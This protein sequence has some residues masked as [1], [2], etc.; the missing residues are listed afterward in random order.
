MPKKT[1]K[2]NSQEPQQPKNTK[3]KKILITIVVCI[4]VVAVASKLVNK[5]LKKIKAEQEKAKIE[6]QAEKNQK[7]K[8]LDNKQSSEET[9]HQT[10]DLISKDTPSNDKMVFTFYNNLKNHRV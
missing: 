2:V 7:S 5:H 1:A 4:L 6:L 10:A 9:N 8:T 3:K